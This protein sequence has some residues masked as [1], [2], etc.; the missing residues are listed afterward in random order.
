M[1][2]LHTPS[3]LKAVLLSILFALACPIAASTNNSAPQEIFDFVNQPACNRLVSSESA[4]VK[5][6]LTQLKEL[7]DSISKEF[8]STDF[9]IVGIGQ[10]PSWLI[11]SLQAQMEDYAFNLPLSNFRP[12]IRIN[13]AVINADIKFPLPQ[14][15]SSQEE[16]RLYDQFEKFIPLSDK[17]ILLVDYS[18]TGATLASV[19]YFMAKYFEEIGTPRKIQVM[20]LTSKDSSQD[21]FRRMTIDLKLMGYFKR[22]D[23]FYSRRLDDPLASVVSNQNDDYTISEFGPFPLRSPPLKVKRSVLYDA[24]VDFL[25][26]L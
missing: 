20:V 16:L 12:L 6:V 14:I 10:S 4:K 26:S 11:A 19:Y 1:R 13:D 23:N 24:L 5:A 9:Q 15:M 17:P 3:L 21:V 22:N 18:T 2:L 8:P 25:R 7:R